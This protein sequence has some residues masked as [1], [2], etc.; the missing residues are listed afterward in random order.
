MS[1]LSAPDGFDQESGA[2]GEGPDG[3]AY[4]AALAALPGIGPV[5]LVRLLRQ[6][7]PVIAWQA[8][9]AGFGEEV[10][11]SAPGATRAASR[12]W[13][14]T[15]RGFDVL[16]RWRAL[17]EAGIGVTYL[18]LPDY[19]TAL[20]HDPHPPGVIFWRGDL[21]ALDR[22]CVAIVG[23]RRCTGYGIGVAALLGRDLAAAGLCVVS[24]LALGIDGAAHA[25]ALEAMGGRTVGV[26][27]SGVD[28]PYPRRHAG[29]WADVVGR[30]AVLSESVPGQ[31]AHSWRF[32]S[33]NRIIA[34]LARAVV[35][36]E[37]HAQGGSMHTVD[38]AADRGIEILAV[39]G[40]VTS[41]ASAGTN[42]LLR[43]GCPPVRHARDVLDQLG[44]F[45]AWSG[46]EPPPS[47][48]APPAVRLDLQLR[49]V[50]AAADW[51]PTSTSVIAAR[52]GLALGPL[53]AALVKL[54]ALGVV[55]GEGGW[56]ER[57]RC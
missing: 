49:R 42:Q 35:I 29:L 54:E 28:V 40:P 57:C 56:W 21:G 48:P 47:S 18:G 12:R 38:A 50:L 17:E 41:P 19:P 16:G 10:A 31:A 25:G 36:V 44:D 46:G 24:G 51:T 5:T 8:V 13:D 26:A 33:R 2:R 15:A 11:G 22:V 39:P 1:G 53:S 7:D 23:T 4:A 9:L 14:E 6:F 45:R 27:A 55:R 52:C 30:G 32:P 20:R 34:G 37:S 3:R 43:D